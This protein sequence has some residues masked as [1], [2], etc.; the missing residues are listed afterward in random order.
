V[1][2]RSS[3]VGAWWLPWSSIITHS[4]KD[5][6]A[7][8]FGGVSFDFE[9]SMGQNTATFSGNS[10]TC[11]GAVVAKSLLTWF[12]KCPPP[13]LLEFSDLRGALT[14]TPRSLRM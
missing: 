11:G 2:V 14:C 13:L 10:G 9:L 8:F 7:R 12:D 3:S 1:I 6:L 4:V 5:D